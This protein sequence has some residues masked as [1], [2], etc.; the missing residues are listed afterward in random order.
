ME[1]SKGGEVGETW[2]TAKMSVRKR[3]EEYC[4]SRIRAKLV[5]VGSYSLFENIWARHKEILQLGAKN[6]AKCDD[7]GGFEV[8]LD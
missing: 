3:Y 6:H 4:T 7:C 2:H 8:E 1:G 5:V